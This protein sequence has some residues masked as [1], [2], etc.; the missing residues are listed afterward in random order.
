MRRPSEQRGFTLI[1]LMVVI[2]IL[3]ILATL[4]IPSLM[5]ML[6][7]TQVRTAAESILDGL[8]VARS[9]AVRRN[10]HTQFVLGPGT[11][12][13]V[14]EINP[15]TSGVACG[16]IATIQTRSGS[17][18]SEKATVAVTGTAGAGATSVTFT[19]TGWTTGSCSAN[20]IAQ[21]NVGSIVLDST[22]E[23]PM[24]IRVTAS[25][26]MRM[27]APWT[28]DATDLNP[29]ASAANWRLPAGDPRRC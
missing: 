18:G 26:G 23:R 25:G 17:E 11:G 9:E 5:E 2:T 6:Q 1:E 27:C 4:G 22:Q 14:S 7:N 21:I 28:G 24:E 19:P 15:P 29:P 20:P 16:I 12:W 10:A 13:T 8:Q 3:A